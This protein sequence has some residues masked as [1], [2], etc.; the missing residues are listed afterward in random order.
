ME[1]LET[2]AVVIIALWLVKAWPDK[3]KRY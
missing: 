2:I 3:E 1:I